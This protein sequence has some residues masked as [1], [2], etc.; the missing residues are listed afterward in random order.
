MLL[1]NTT[2]NSHIVVKF[3]SLTDKDARVGNKSKTKQFF[4]YK[5]EI[6][7]TNSGIITAVTVNPGNY[8]WNCQYMYSH[9]IH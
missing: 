9:K 1:T 5:A 7:M 2:R 3:R 6:A 8:V 4:G